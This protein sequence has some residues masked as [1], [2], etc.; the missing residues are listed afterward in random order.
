MSAQIKPNIIE[1]LKKSGFE[2][3][4]AELKKQYYDFTGYPK[5][6]KRYILSFKSENYTVEEMYFWMLGHGMN[7]WAMPF[8]HKITDIFAASQ[9]STMFG[10]LGSRMTAMQNQASNLLASFGQM[11]KDLFK[12]V[13]DL[14]KL[15]ERLSYYKKADENLSL[16]ER[17]RKSALGAENTLKDIWI[18]LVEGGTENP[19]SVYGMARKVGFTILPD[20]FFQAPPLKEDEIKKYV[21]DLDTGNPTVK[22]AVERKLYQYY[23][24]KKQTWEELK[25]REKYQKKLIYQHYQNMKL[26]LN[27]IKPYLKNSQKL[28][29]NEDLMNAYGVISSF[30]TSMVEIEVLLQKPVKK[31]SYSSPYKDVKP[32]SKRVNEVV[33]LHF[34]YETSPEM[35]FHAK[36][37]WQQKGPSHVG[38]VD[39]TIR[40]YGWTDDEIEKY[41][42][43]KREEEISLIKSIDHTLANDGDL[44]GEDL[45]QILKEVEEEISGKSDKDSTPDMKSMDAKIKEQKKKIDEAKKFMYG[46]FEALFGGLFGGFKEILI[47][48]I[49]LRPKTKKYESYLS[50][51]SEAKA[52]AAKMASVYAWQIYKNYKKAHRMVTW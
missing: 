52:K 17:K 30:Q 5:P 9:G 4:I 26:Y 16:E 36:D 20:L 47:D 31:I 18:T 28:S 21:E 35:S 38:R 32:E 37:S 13:R 6:N 23:H 14:R 44:F 40:S 49:L 2:P 10:D 42:N 15:R 43:V 46:P 7:D 45:M 1:A 51:L 8:I 19:G 27:W 3:E 22:L 11:S 39:A 33:I 34:L 29:S 48:P 25:F 12:H 24:W 50:D 41:K